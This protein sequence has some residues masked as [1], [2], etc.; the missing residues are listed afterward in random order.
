MFSGAS[1]AEPHDAP[2]S[3]RATRPAGIFCV[4][5]RSAALVGGASFDPKTAPTPTDGPRK[6]ISQPSSP[7]QCSRSKGVHSLRWRIALHLGS[8]QNPLYCYIS[9]FCRPLRTREVQLSC[10]ISQEQEYKCCIR[11]HDNHQYLEKTGI[12]ARSRAKVKFVMGIVG[13]LQI[14]IGVGRSFYCL[15]SVGFKTGT[16]D[17]S[18]KCLWMSL[19]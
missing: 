9:S 19:M 15:E 6:P 14:R 17:P 10:S 8:S 18:P 5:D 16:E 7:V 3:P 1:I 4:A 12:P 13:L 11:S 2:R